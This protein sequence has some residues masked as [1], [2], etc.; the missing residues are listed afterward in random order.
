MNTATEPTNTMMTALNELADAW[1]NEHDA[2][3]AMER[4]NAAVDLYLQNSAATK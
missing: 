2:P 3:E 4:F 1:E